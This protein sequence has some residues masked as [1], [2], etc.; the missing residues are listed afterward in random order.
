MI[1]TVDEVKT[2]CHLWDTSLPYVYS[3]ISKFPGAKDADFRV[4]LWEVWATWT[5]GFLVEMGSSRR[6]TPLRDLEINLSNGT[7]RDNKCACPEGLPSTKLCAQLQKITAFFGFK[8]YHEG[9]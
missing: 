1:G 7:V 5:E 9:S 8:G 4:A 3:A 6:T 2:T